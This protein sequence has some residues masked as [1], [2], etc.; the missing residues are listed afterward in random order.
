M[1][2]SLSLTK[3]SRV[4]PTFDFATF[5]TSKTRLAVLSD[6]VSYKKLIKY[7]PI[8][9]EIRISCKYLTRRVIRSDS[10]ETIA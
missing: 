4:T 3:S 10:S 7:E 5:F 9:I 6:F 2:A 8:S 1:T